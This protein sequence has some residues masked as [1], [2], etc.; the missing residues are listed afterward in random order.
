MPFGLGKVTNLIRNVVQ[1]IPA[2]T[3]P[4]GHA[5][6]AE[7]LFPT[8]TPEEQSE[9]E[10]SQECH[11]CPEYPRSFTKIGIDTEDKL[12]GHVAGWATHCIVATGETDWLHN[13]YDIK[14]SVMAALGEQVDHRKVKNGKMMISASNLPLPEDH[15]HLDDKEGTASEHRKTKVVILPAFVVVEGVTAE[16]APTIVDEF[17]NK[18]PTT[19]DPLWHVDE[20]GVEQPSE[21]AAGIA[22]PQPTVEKDGEPTNGTPGSPIA[23]R[24]ADV[25]AA[26][27]KNN[28]SSSSS[29]DDDATGAALAKAITN[30]SLRT[31]HLTVTPY[32][33]DYLILLC[34]HRK[35]DARCGISAPI[36]KKEFERHL[37]PLGLWRDHTDQREGGASVVFINHVGGHKYSANCI[38]Y[39]K[40]DGQGIWLAR[41]APKNVEGIVKKTILEG[42]LVDPAM[43]RGG[44]N[45]KA[46]LVSW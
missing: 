41:V 39:R 10:C 38:I 17:V 25:L 22:E 33:H 26:E 23:L 32:P 44:F 3:G 4:T 14:G 20:N 30:L 6:T 18:G 36:I 42:K 9:L 21:V 46:G 1:P 8:I 40:K 27:K 16:D 11:A 19:V 5:P 13:I 35:R 31:P 28:S 12:Y 43:V 37:R 7:T 2:T 45:R 34:S 29:A 24:T 15:D